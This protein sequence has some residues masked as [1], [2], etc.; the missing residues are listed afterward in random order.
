MSAPTSRRPSPFRAAVLGLCGGMLLGGVY[1]LVAGL[2]ARF[3]GLDCAGLSA[4][5][6]ELLRET[7]RDVSRFQTLAGGALI[8][9]AAALVVLVRP[10][11][12]PPGDGGTA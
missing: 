9:L 7:A 3:S 8:A 5:E 12:P 1:M 6:C 11:T 2:R 10:R 4:P